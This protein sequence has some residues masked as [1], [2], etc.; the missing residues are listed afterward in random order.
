MNGQFETEEKEW[1][2]N[3]AADFSGLNWDR[4][5]LFFELEFASY[6]S[7]DVRKITG[8]YDQ[9]VQIHFGEVWDYS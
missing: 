1:R 3:I 6:P 4:A 5:L 7:T 8:D 2:S 9:M